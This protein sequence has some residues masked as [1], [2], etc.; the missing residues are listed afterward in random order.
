MSL[1]DLFGR[2]SPATQTELPRFLKWQDEVVGIVNKDLSLSITNKSIKH[3][4]L[5]FGDDTIWTRE[6]FKDFLSDRIPSSQRRDIEQILRKAGLTEYNVFKLARATRAFNAKDLLWL[7]D[8]EG[9]KFS[10]Y[11]PDVMS[12]VFLY[13]RDVEGDAVHSPEGVNQKRYGIS[14][15]HYGIYKKRLNPSSS[16]VE[17]EVAVYFLARALGVPCCPAWLVE[18]PKGDECFSQFEYNFSS[19]YIVHLRRLFKEGEQAGEIYTT[20]INKL[21]EFAKEISQMVLLDFVSRQTD[22]HMSNVALLVTGERVT[23]YPLYDNGRSLFF[24][25]KG[26]LISRAVKDIQGYSESFGE[27][28][29]Y[30]DAVLEVSKRYKISELVNLDVTEHSIWSYYAKAKLK[31]VRLRGAH[32]WTTKCLKFLKTLDS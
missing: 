26:D 4:K 31:N 17:C 15:G 21:P 11:L 10:D 1:T 8:N 25:D 3:L 22:R 20:L 29:T 30:H 27:I 13:S 6:R 2:I 14:R 12:S 18:T 9:D 28:G 16:D 5:I 32:E 23:F 7:A 24:E 19:Q